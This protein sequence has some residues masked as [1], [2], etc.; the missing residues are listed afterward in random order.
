[1]NANISAPL[2]AADL[3][4]PGF[5]LK[6]AQV[7]PCMPAAYFGGTNICG[8]GFENRVDSAEAMIAG[9]YYPWYGTNSAD[10]VFVTPADEVNGN[11]YTWYWN[12]P[13]DFN[14][15]GSAG[16]FGL[17]FFL[18]G[19]PSLDGV[20]GNHPNDN[21]SASFDSYVAFPTAGFYTV[22]VSSDD[23]F[24]LSQGWGVSR[25][26]LHV[27]GASVERD[28]AAIPSTPS[29]AGGVWQG[30]LPTVPITAPIA[31]V[32]NTGCPGPT[33]LDLTGKIALIDGN[34][35]K[36]DGD[37][38]PY[39]DLVAMCQARGALA[40]I[41][42]SS[43]GWGTI[44]VMTGGTTPITIP[45]LHINGYGGEKDWFHTNGPLVATIGGDTH[46]KLGE[47]DF[48]KGMDHQDFGFVVP[49]PGLYPL[50]LIYEQGGGGAGLEWSIIPTP[51]LTLDTTN[52]VVM[53]SGST[54]SLLSYRA[55]TTPPKFTS[56]KTANGALTLVWFGGGVLQQS[57]TISPASWTDVNPQPPGD[58][59]TVM[60]SGPAKFYRLRR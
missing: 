17:N 54:G 29:T 31:Y 7:D 43:P 10:P 28:V 8:Q 32:D 52:R 3:S 56:V 59:Y 14:I 47:A 48:G 53:N 23:G 51:D 16:D 11:S 49:A 30:N 25:E 37:D 9:L 44:E 57:S 15:T 42:Q 36:A 1:L 60:T 5:V 46:L 4:K 2:A 39:N 19:I 50:H 45:A 6:V 34:R 13:V 20:P 12:N 22:G 21:F 27:K 58:T 26:I 55:I 38:G 33:T 41:L 40:V 24:R 18:P 35:C